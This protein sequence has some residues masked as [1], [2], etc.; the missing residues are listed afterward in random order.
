[1][2][3]HALSGISR[4]NGA[5]IE[6]L[7]GRKAET[8][9]VREGISEGFRPAKS[10]R[11]V[12]GGVEAEGHATPPPSYSGRFMPTPEEFALRQP[13]AFNARARFPGLISGADSGRIRSGGAGLS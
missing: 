13:P 10:E 11:A 9:R 12:P 4:R 7:P 8:D 5:P 1:V 2:G 3:W 6:T